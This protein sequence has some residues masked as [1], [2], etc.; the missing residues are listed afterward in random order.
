M[1]KHLKIKMETKTTNRFLKSFTI[2]SYCPLS[3]FITISINF[4]EP[5]VTPINHIFAL[6]Y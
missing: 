2:N 1:S 5:T 6:Q 4:V 3:N